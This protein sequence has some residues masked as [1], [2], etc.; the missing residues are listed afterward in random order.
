MSKEI[1][2]EKIDKVIARTGVSY[3]KAKIA[4]EINKGDVIDSIIYIESQID[5]T[6]QTPNRDSYTNENGS[7]SGQESSVEDI[8][9]MIK[10][11]VKEGNVNRIK[12]SNN[13]KELINTSVNKSLIALGVGTVFFA[14]IMLVLVGLGTFGVLTSE[15]TIEVIKNDG[16]VE[17]ISKTLKNKVDS[18][19][20]KD[21]INNVKETAKKYGN[22]AKS[23]IDEI[24]NKQQNK[25]EEERS[26]K[27]DFEDDY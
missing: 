11:I 13:G 12:I 8:M 2:L 20:F 17:T 14:P 22:D 5:I 10:N 18:D 27:I 19:K 16:S 7:E 24:K 4:L 15:I 3:Q 1:T 6:S 25:G 23:K 26:Y 21:T 9:Q